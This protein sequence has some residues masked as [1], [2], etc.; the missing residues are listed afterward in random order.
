MKNYKINIVMDY[1]IGG[2]FVGL[3]RITNKLP[4]YKWIF[5]T[6]V[7]KESDIII[8][9]NNNRHYKAAKI[10]NIR[11]IIQRKTG[12]RSLLV[13]T[14]EDLSAVIC[15]SKRS[16]E[17]TNHDKKTL[18]YNGVDFEYIKNI[19]PKE[20]VDLLVAE[21]RIGI[22]Q[23]VN[24]A[25]KYA[26]EHNRHLTILGSKA[27]LEENTYNILKKTY[28]Q[29]CWVGTVSPDESLSFIKGCNA[30]I[31][32]NPSHGVANQIIEAVS[33]DK[34]IICLCNSLEIP[35]KDQIDINVT[36]QKYHEMIQK[37]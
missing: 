17:L 3:E 2:A 25:C 10:Y 20:K 35:S 8:Y 4:Q 22:G 23:R 32:G 16:Y 5:S 11:Y 19:Q 31:V 36:A 21:S 29:F 9:M 12:E 33:M 24:E 30:I 15:A 27:N 18:I 14:P 34:Q 6:E 7:D 37:L 28:P 26:I 13:P 1:L